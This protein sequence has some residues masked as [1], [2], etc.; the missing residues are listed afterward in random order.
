MAKSLMFAEKYCL[1]AFKSTYHALAAEKVLDIGLIEQ[2]VIPTPK[3][4]S[5]SCGLALKIYISDYPQA[6]SL[7]L[8]RGLREVEAYEVN[9]GE[10]TSYNRLVISP[11]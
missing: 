4:I 1:I 9:S 10:Q 7:L 8:E 2:V 11:S 3:Q 6:V 5:A